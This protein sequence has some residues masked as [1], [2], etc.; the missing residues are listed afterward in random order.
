[1]E[2]KEKDQSKI[3]FWKAPTPKNFK[4]YYRDLFCEWNK[5]RKIKFE[6]DRFDEDRD[7]KLEDIGFSR[8]DMLVV[9]ITSN[10]GFI[11]HP[12]EKIQV[13]GLKNLGDDIPAE[14]L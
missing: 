10:D 7:Q 9:E 5:Y 14:W 1:M 8:D 6:G 2:Y 12:I 3:R 4:D 13:E 11:L